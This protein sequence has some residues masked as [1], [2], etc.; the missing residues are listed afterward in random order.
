MLG[1]S[2]RGRSVFGVS[3]V[4]TAACGLLSLQY[5]L[6]STVMTVFTASRL[7]VL[8]F[9]P[10]SHHKHA[11]QPLVDSGCYNS[12]PVHRPVL[13]VR[14][15]R[16]TCYSVSL[17]CIPCA[18]VQMRWLFRS[19]TRAAGAFRHNGA[20]NFQSFAYIRPLGSVTTAYKIKRK[21]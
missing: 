12:F 3:V 7:S 20:I 4:R 16:R 1:D 17:H 15:R 21:P 5:V 14:T 13:P 10:A 18:S 19:A 2:S 8:Q 6:L 11:M 9:T